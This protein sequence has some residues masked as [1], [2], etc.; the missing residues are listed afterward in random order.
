VPAHRVG[1]AF[2][3]AIGSGFGSGMVAA[4]ISMHPLAVSTSKKIK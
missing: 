2:I 4:P 1:A 3:L